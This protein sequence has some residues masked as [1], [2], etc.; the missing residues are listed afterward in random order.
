MI[1]LEHVTF[2]YGGAALLSVGR[3]VVG[4][5]ERVMLRGPSGSGKS[6]LL[7]LMAGILV[8]QG[9]SVKVGG[10]EISTKSDA[11]RRAFRVN[12]LGFIFQDFALLPH[13]DV[14]DNV[15]LPYRINPAL[16]LNGNVRARAAGLLEALGIAG[17]ANAFPEKLSFGERQRAAIARAMIAEP[18][19]VLAD[20]PT[21]NLDRANALKTVELILESAA[22]NKAAAVVVS[23]DE[24]L[25]RYF[26]RVVEMGEF[27]VR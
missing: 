4:A 7:N 11:Q 9:G 10:E 3:F 1:Q 19:V 20:E 24:G 25:S 8:P 14:A 12:R 13:L 5:G 27:Q 2:G 15:L 6:T 16:K 23:H 17:K 21:A 18:A 26:D 22:R